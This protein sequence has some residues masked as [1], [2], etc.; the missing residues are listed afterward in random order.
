MGKQK[1]L[2]HSPRHDLAHHR[3]NS[4]SHSVGPNLSL[5]FLLW[6]EKPFGRETACQ[7]AGGLAYTMPNGLVAV[8]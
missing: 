7:G 1:P 8:L 6:V 2:R 3:A 5:F 4:Q